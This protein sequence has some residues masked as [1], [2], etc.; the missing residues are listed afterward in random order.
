MPE[1]R[2]LKDWLRHAFAVDE[3]PFEP[4]PRQAAVADRLCREIVRRR[5]TTPALAFLEMSRPMNYM[6]AQAV[7][8]FTP[9]IKALT[10]TDARHFAEFLEHRASIE[11]LCRRLEE[12]EAQASG[13]ERNET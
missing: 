11:Y 1:R 4:T 12:L 8:F 2:T 3:G 6:G 10:D 7:H 5:L 9:L 13:P